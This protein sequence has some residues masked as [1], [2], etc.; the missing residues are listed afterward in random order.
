M[1]FIRF[2]TTIKH[3]VSLFTLTH[4][5]RLSFNTIATERLDLKGF[6]YVVLFY[7]EGRKTIKI[8]LTNDDKETGVLPL[9]QTPTGAMINGKRFLD[10]F[11]IRPSLR[12]AYTIRATSPHILLVNLRQPYERKWVKVK[13]E[14]ISKNPK[15]TISLRG[16]QRS[17]YQRFT[18]SS[19]GL[20]PMMTLS[21][22]GR[23]TFNAACRDRY[24]ITSYKYCL[25]FYDEVTKFI[26]IKLTNNVQ[27]EGVIPLDN[28]V[29]STH[30]SGKSFLKHF[31]ILPEQSTMYRL[32]CPRGDDFIVDL[33]NPHVKTHRIRQPKVKPQD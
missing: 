30:I 14:S 28:N 6:K 12:D 32:Y 26:K 33:N 1:S 10:Y 2:S 11:D 20:T 24:R 31:N 16:Y 8:Q 4:H 5:G 25:L 15:F 29:V 23:M 17:G 22:Y 13:K 27:E 18:H 19:R 3:V 7:H 9:L 21:S